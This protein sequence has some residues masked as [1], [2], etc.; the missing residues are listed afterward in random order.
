MIQK[1]V[2][3]A[4]VSAVGVV[5]TQALLLLAF[6]GFGWSAVTSNLFAVSVAS[7]PV[8]VLNRAWVWGK[9]DRVSHLR[10]T[11]PFWVMTLLGLGV[12]T[13][14]VAVAAS[15]NDAWYIVSAANIGGFGLVWIAKFVVLEKVLF[16]DRTP[17]AVG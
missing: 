15:V 1:F 8:F 11:L 13:V 6:G 12:S 9:T 14:C 4:A 16:V 5:I 10:E 7:V 2:R 17:Q 3:Y